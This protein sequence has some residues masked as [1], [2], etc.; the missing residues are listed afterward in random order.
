M[1]RPFNSRVGDCGAGNV[2]LD[3]AFSN[4]RVLSEFNST[5]VTY[6]VFWT[7]NS[8]YL[9]AEEYNA[10][11]VVDNFRADMFAMQHIRVG[12]GSCSHSMVDTMHSLP[13]GAS[14]RGLAC[15]IVLIVL[16]GGCV[17][18]KGSAQRLL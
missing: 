11:I 10:T 14:V 13:C 8:S 12:L 3:A 17:A 5:D 9:S 1:T 7:M 2:T 6:Q 16:H 15:A 4:A 18:C